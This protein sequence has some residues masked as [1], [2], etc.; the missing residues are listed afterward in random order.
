LLG[1]LAWQHLRRGSN[2][3]AAAAAIHRV[4]AGDAPSR[5]AAISDLESFG[6]EAPEAA[7]AALWS[8]LNDD[9]A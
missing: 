3:G 5:I 1:I 6:P 2:P 4:R 7:I 8:T 9:D